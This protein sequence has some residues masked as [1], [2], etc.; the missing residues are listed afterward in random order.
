MSNY[1]FKL[2]NGGETEGDSEGIRTPV[3]FNPVIPGRTLQKDTD[4]DPVYFKS[5]IPIRVEPIRPHKALAAIST[6]KRRPQSRRIESRVK[7]VCQAFLVL[8]LLVPV[9]LLATSSAKSF[10]QHAAIAAVNNVTGSTPKTALNSS[11]NEVQTPTIIQGIR[12]FDG[13]S[14]ARLVIELSNTPN[15]K[16]LSGA[17]TLAIKFESAGLGA[18][19]QQ[20]Q[21]ETNGL[22]KQV[23]ATQ[24]D[25]TVDMRLRFR[26]GT[27]FAAFALG[28][29]SRLVIDVRDDDSTD[30]E[31]AADLGRMYTPLTNNGVVKRIVIDAGHGGR[32]L[33]AL[34]PD[35]FAEKEVTLEVARLLK[36]DIESR[37]GIEVVL[38]RDG[39]Y[40]VPLPV[41]SQKANASGADLFISLHANAAEASESETGEES[42]AE[43]NAGVDAHG[44]ETYFLSRATSSA[45]EQIAARENAA[46]GVT[47]PVE[48]NNGAK[49]IESHLLATYIQRCLVRG[50]RSATPS[51]AR[52]R[53]VKQAPFF[54]LNNTQIPSVLVEVSFITSRD[55]QQRLRTSAFRQ[56]IADS[57]LEGVRSYI[58]NVSQRKA[59]GEDQI[60]IR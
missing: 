51:A 55:D 16:A 17:N 14:F 44:V 45:A 60:V 46:G 27:S 28:S 50:L 18:S 32:D 42:G 2:G 36:H 54:V 31:L 8:L 35:G 48:Q 9:G 25:G 43:K 1:F 23:I 5:T 29:P 56:K 33:G 3:F 6:L 58:L 15:F 49:V 20:T 59:T 19:F 47:G 39:D 24:T 22:V 12:R 7:L 40:Y 38:T 53:G 11:T 4:H 13:G 41:R 26:P 52:D 34:S 30:S 37:L 57:L 10:V 21:T